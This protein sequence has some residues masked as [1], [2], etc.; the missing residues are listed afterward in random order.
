MM[1]NIQDYL[2]RKIVGTPQQRIGIGGFT[3]LVTIEEN[4]T[5][6]ANIPATVVEDGS[7]VNDHIILDQIVLSI[8]GDVSDVYIERSPVT[9]ALTRAQAEVGVVTQYAPPRTQAQVQQVNA[10]IN[11]LTD[12]V[13]RVDALLDS[14]QQVLN[15][16][17]NKDQQSKTN[18]ELFLDA[19]ESIWY[20]KQ[21]ISIETQYRRW[22]NMVLTLVDT[23][24]NNTDGS[25]KFSIEAREFRLASTIF[26]E[27]K[28]AANPSLGLGGQT[29]PE[30]AK[31]V[32]EGTPADSSLLFTLIG[33]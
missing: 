31:G 19:M 23:A 20:G 7:Y 8:K 11:D 32:Q 28:P 25:T 3:A 4:T 12:A 9:E 29:D 22:D 18:R 6:T 1:A 26:T 5:R 16:F 13:R 10:L 33:R 30:D 15:Y 2:D 24:D 27:I 21:L 17:G 14:G